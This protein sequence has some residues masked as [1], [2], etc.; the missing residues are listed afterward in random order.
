MILIIW[1]IFFQ[2]HL[3]GHIFSHY[4]S[5]MSSPLQLKL[6]HRMNLL[7]LS[8][9]KSD[10]SGGYGHH[11]SSADIKW[12]EWKNDYLEFVSQLYDTPGVPDSIIDALGKSTEKLK[13]IRNAEIDIIAFSLSVVPIVL[14]WKK[15][16]KVSGRI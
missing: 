10:I 15:L 5:I 1:I 4:F 3:F 6:R 11:C 9:Q 2:S 16:L 7:S 13:T 8:R 14:K 12:L